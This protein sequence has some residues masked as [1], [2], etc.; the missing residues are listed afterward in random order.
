LLLPW[1]APFKA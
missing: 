1:L